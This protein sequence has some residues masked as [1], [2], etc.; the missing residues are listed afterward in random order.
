MR[1]VHNGWRW[2]SR[3]SDEIGLNSEPYWS[4][5]F[6]LCKIALPRLSS[7]DN[8]FQL[9]S[10]AAEDVSNLKRDGCGVGEGSLRISRITV[11]G[12]WG[13]SSVRVE[14]LCVCVVGLGVCVCM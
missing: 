11:N 5:D 1:R 4:G 12:F 2:N 7:S 9:C 10:A 13:H 14:S 8:I 3:S 6:P